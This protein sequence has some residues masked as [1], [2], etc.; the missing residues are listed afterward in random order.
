VP[1][2]SPA[3]DGALQPGV[4]WVY[5]LWVDRLVIGLGALL[6]AVV[7]VVVSSSS[8][9][10]DDSLRR[11]VRSLSAPDRDAGATISR[12]PK[13]PNFDYI[14]DLVTNQIHPLPSQIRQS[15]DDPNS[16]GEYAVS[17]DGTAIAYVRVGPD[18]RGRILIA[19]GNRPGVGALSD[20]QI[21]ARSPAW[22]PNSTKLVYV[23]NRP[24]EGSGDL[25]VVDLRSGRATQITQHSGN[26]YSPQF[27]PDGTRVLYTVGPNCCPLLRTVPTSGGTS[28]PLFDLHG[29]LTS[30]GNGSLSPDGSLVTF[31]SGGNP[32]SGNPEHCRLCRWL[33]NPNGTHMRVIQVECWITNPAGAW[34]PDS[35]RIVCSQGEGGIIV[36]NVATGHTSTVASGQAASWLDGHTLIV[37]I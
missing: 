37:E 28:R 14:L 23:A 9:E 12:V 32:T 29:G 6:I 26:P 27:T 3:G 7:V 30:T 20:R 1:D 19:R 5:V 15:L 18:T 17:P 36:V 34:S 11:G 13:A 2:A 22:S 21:D 31:L 24:G 25:V 4:W 8:F 35:S 10:G 33:A 16:G